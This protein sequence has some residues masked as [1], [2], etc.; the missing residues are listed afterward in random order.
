[1]GCFRRSATLRGV[2]Q[3]GPQDAVGG[4][5]LLGLKPATLRADSTPLIDVCLLGHQA[6]WSTLVVAG[7]RMMNRMKL[8]EA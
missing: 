3:Q 6:D 8:S 1:M 2:H 5:Q 7:G 4:P